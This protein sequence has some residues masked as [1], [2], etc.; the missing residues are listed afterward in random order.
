MLV[1]KMPI[2]RGGCHPLWQS[3]LYGPSVFV[4]SVEFVAA[5]KKRFWGSFTPHAG[6]TTV[7]R[8]VRCSHA[9]CWNGLPCPEH[10]PGSGVSA[11]ALTAEQ[12]L[13]P[14]VLSDDT[15]L[16]LLKENSVSALPRLRAARR[17]SFVAAVTFG[18]H[19]SLN[20]H[21]FLLFRPPS[22][23]PRATCVHRVDADSVASE[24]GQ[25]SFNGAV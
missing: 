16:N 21:V 2:S 17:K 15:I 13:H 23:H 25:R 4:H 18:Q 8:M 7:L 3:T 10:G 12:M 19:A 11:T 14:D 1:R 24:G 6:T 22:S 9:G 5:F 20:I